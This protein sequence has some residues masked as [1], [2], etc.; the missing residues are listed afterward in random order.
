MLRMLQLQIVYATQGWRL[1]GSAEVV[2]SWSANGIKIQKSLAF[3]SYAS[4]ANLQLK[5]RFAMTAWL[6]QQVN[7]LAVL[8]GVR[9]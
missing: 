4:M 7:K 3:V 6:F 2:L 5:I 8:A 9:I 1:P